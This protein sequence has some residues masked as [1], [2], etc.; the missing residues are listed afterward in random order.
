MAAAEHAGLREW[1]EQ[2]Q[3]CVRNVDFDAGRRLFVEDVV[4]FGTKANVVV[5]LEPL[6]ASQW[7]GIWPN[8]SDFTFQ[9][10][11]LHTG[12]DGSLAWGV[13]PWTS[14][15]Y[16]PDGVAFD[17]PGRATVIFERRGNRWLAKHTHFSLNP[18][19][20]PTTHGRRGR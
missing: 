6:V 18:G 14:T 20:P 7:S 5:G 8:I 17:R 2:L 13:A 15:G 10:E 12:Q 3:T 16:R 11:Q 9:L 1:F 19:T 4:A